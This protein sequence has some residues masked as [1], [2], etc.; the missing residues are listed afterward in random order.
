MALLG[1]HRLVQS[2]VGIWYMFFKDHFDHSV[3]NGVLE[4]G[5]F[6]RTSVGKRRPYGRFSIRNNDNWTRVMAVHMK[7]NG[8]IQ[9]IFHRTKNIEG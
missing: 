7:G 6:R 5:E 8:Q 2:T 3:D 4:S 9:D 1:S